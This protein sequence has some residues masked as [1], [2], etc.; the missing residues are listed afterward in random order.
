[1]RPPADVGQRRWLCANLA[2]SIIQKLR[3]GQTEDT[4]EKL[5]SPSSTLSTAEAISTVNQGL[6]MALHF[7]N[8]TLSVGDLAAGMASAVVKDPTSDAEVW[9]EYRETVIRNRTGW[10][11]LYEACA[12]LAPPQNKKG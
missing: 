12:A 8:G 1:M 3:D 11:D 5:R 4:R 6:A 9:R 7:G 10:K 2:F